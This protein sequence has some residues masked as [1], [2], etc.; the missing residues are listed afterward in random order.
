MGM[1]KKIILVILVL[2]FLTQAAE[3]APLFSDP[4]P[5]NNSYIYGKNTDLFSVNVSEGN[6]NTTTVKL[7][8]R[9]EDPT[10]V[11]TTED[12]ECFLIS[13]PNWFCNS[14]ISNLES[15]VHDG[16]WLL[17]YF[18]A[19]DTF[20]GYGNL[21]NSSNPLRVRIDRSPPNIT[22]IFP[23]NES[24]SSGNITI[25]IEVIDAY[26]TVNLSSVSY[27]FD[28]STWLAVTTE[29]NKVFKSVEKWNTGIYSNNQT[30]NLYAKASDVLNNSGNVKIRTT[31]DNELPRVFIVSPSQNQT[32]FGDVTIGLQAEDTYSGLEFS[33]I[34]Y[35]IQTSS[36]PFSCFGSIYN[37][38]CTTSLATRFVQDGYH[39]LIFKV[40]DRAKNERTNS[41]FVVIDNLPPQV[42]ILSPSP[43]STVSG[44]VNVSASVKDDGVGVANVSFRIESDGAAGDWEKMYCVGDYCSVLWNSTVFVDGTYNLRV[45]SMDKLGRESS[46]VVRFS[47]V[48]TQPL[49]SAGTT[50]TTQPQAEGKSLSEF[51]SNFI[52]KIRKNPLLVAGLIL[53]L[54]ILPSSLYLLSRKETVKKT[55][56]G[57][58]ED[59]TREYMMTINNIQSLAL[60][61]IGSQDINEL[62]D[63][64]RLM[65]IYLRDLEKDFSGKMIGKILSSI[66]DEK[67][68]AD[69]KR[70]LGGMMGEIDNIRRLKREYLEEITRS[71][72]DILI[73]EDVIRAQRNLE[74][75][76][77]LIRKFRGL[78]DRE[79]AILSEGMRRLKG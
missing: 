70:Y 65:L 40:L 17:Y 19:Y 27:S 15:L 28:N 11:W 74:N 58:M 22:F 55:Q 3:A 48:N 75:V 41:T 72:N 79:I 52:D 31:A 33:S 71:L 59:D 60:S 43:A 51:A 34:N 69:F 64:T 20:G 45:Y 18:D 26:S 16:N 23:A 63:K 29:D 66:K 4:V 32:L 50:T 35:F 42:K 7:H 39:Q 67:F 30:V 57:R 54:I 6:L 61:S 24:F 9:V 46:M 5:Q 62:K 56:T 13:L 1:F 25:E 77:S 10:S 53:P 12:M 8:A 38:N 44:N 14:T 73:E 76:S 2:I 47:V 36:G 37:A 78:V 21:G 68:T 49:P